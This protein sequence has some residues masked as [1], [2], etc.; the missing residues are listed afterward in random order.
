MFE[1]TNDSHVSPARSEALIGRSGTRWI[2]LALSRTHSFLL[3][4]CA[5]ARTIPGLLWLLLI[6]D[7]YVHACMYVT[8][9]VN[10]D[11]L[12]VDRERRS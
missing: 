5:R 1:Y 12:V 2:D 3:G 11:P 4:Q 9:G 7:V 6:I 10:H 8:M